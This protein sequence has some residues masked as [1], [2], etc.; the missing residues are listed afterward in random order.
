MVCLVGDG[1]RPFCP[2]G[3]DYALGSPALE[4]A[5]MHL[6]NGHTFHRI[7]HDLT[8]ANVYVESVRL[9]GQPWRSPFLPC[10]AVE[11][12]GT[13]EFQMGPR[14]VRAIH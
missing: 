14:P 11:G 7:A 10:S 12:G 9:N 5:T 8:D 13:L 3:T 2:G 6:S 1:F 4:S